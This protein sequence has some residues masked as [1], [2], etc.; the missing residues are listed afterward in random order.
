MRGSIFFIILIC[1]SWLVCAETVTQLSE[2]RN[3]GS[4]NIDGEKV[5]I[6]DGPEVFIFK[7]KDFAL[8]RRFGKRGEGPGEFKTYPNFNRGGVGVQV[9]PDYLLINSVGRVSFFSKT[10]EYIREI[11][12]R[13]SLSRCV[14]L[15]NQFAGFKLLVE[16][17]LENIYVTLYDQNFKKTRSIRKI[18][19]YDRR[20]KLDPTQTF[21]IPSLV[22]ED[23]KV[24]FND[25]EGNIYIHDL[26]GNPVSKIKPL[27]PT[28]KVLALTEERK[29]RYIQTFKTDPRIRGGYENFKKI[30]EFPPFF[31]MLRTFRVSSKK[32]YV[33]TY[34]EQ[35]GLRELLIYDL[36]GNFIKQHYIGLDGLNAIEFYPF[37]IKNNKIYQLIEDLEHEEWNIHVKAIK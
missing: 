13:V 12:N 20:H 19:F 5:Y 35:K 9:H 3:P 31:P 24:F 26:L 4:I 2:L 8:I 15:E 7:L 1:L 10:G 6:N 29:K 25:R 11:K 36:K 22:F 33:V 23:E 21:R 37:T 14:L 18:L 28:G 27:G 16:G 17:E 32:I 30:I 34:R